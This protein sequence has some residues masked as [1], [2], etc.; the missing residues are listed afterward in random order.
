VHFLFRTTDG[1]IL[2]GG[3]LAVLVLFAVGAVVLTGARTE[4][5]HSSSVTTPDGQVGT[6][7]TKEDLK[8][9]NGIPPL[10]SYKWSPSNA[11]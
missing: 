10:S 6:P 9:M 3:A 1:A 2:L 7:W 8:R 5:I 11:H 4:F